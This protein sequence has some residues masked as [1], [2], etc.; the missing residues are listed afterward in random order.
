MSFGAFGEQIVR[1]DLLVHS[2]LRS[3][4]VRGVA[5]GRWRSGRALRR[6]APIFRRIRNPPNISLRIGRSPNQKI[7]AVASQ[8]QTVRHSRRHTASARKS[9]Q[10]DWSLDLERL[11]T[12]KPASLRAHDQHHTLVPK[13][14]LPVKTDHADRNFHPESSAAARR[15]G[16]Q[17]FHGGVAQLKTSVAPH[18]CDRL[19][20]SSNGDRSNFEPKPPRVA[21]GWHLAFEWPQRFF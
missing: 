21:S 20:G 18:Y 16:Y 6:D 5:V 4:L 10:H 2:Q 8:R 14:S 9:A 3:I 19:A 11:R 15:L 17:N 7:L 1:P 13:R 12:P